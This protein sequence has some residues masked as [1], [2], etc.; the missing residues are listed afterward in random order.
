VAI[1]SYAEDDGPKHI[2]KIQGRFNFSIH[3]EFRY[4][5]CNVTDSGKIFV[6][7][8]FDGTYL[9]ITALGMI[10]LLREYTQKTPALLKF[11]A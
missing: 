2:I 9:D 7:D 4:A 3:L 10:L 5:C 11:A 8:F 1:Q 6:F